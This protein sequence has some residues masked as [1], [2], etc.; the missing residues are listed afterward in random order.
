MPQGG[1]H[2]LHRARQTAG[3]GSPQVP[4]L[5]LPG[6]DDQVRVIVRG[7]GCLRVALTVE[8][9]DDINGDRGAIVTQIAQ[10][11]VATAVG[12]TA[13]ELDLARLVVDPGAL[14]GGYRWDTSVGLMLHFVFW[15]LT[16]IIP[17]FVFS[18]LDTSMAKG[19]L[20]SCSSG[21]YR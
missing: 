17:H 5:G 13:S 21:R 2:Q 16:V 8:V 1:P 20:R 15:R 18:L 19:Y 6:V 7:G 14:L 10:L 9:F 3:D 12:S 4:C 11:T